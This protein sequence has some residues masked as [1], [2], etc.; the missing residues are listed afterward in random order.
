M[1]QVVNEVYALITVSTVLYY[2]IGFYCI[3]A[4]LKRAL[5]LKCRRLVIMI[6]GLI[7]A[8][9]L[10]YPWSRLIFIFAY[11]SN[12]E[13]LYWLAAIVG[14]A[15]GSLIWFALWTFAIKLWALAQSLKEIRERPFYSRGFIVILQ[16]VGISALAIGTILLMV[17]EGLYESEALLTA[18]NAFIVVV[19]ISIVCVFYDAYRQIRSVGGEQEI[20]ILLDLKQLQMFVI[21]FAIILIPQIFMLLVA[22]VAFN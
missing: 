2:P 1:T 4:I 21:A 19:N 7:S 14:C 15:S 22:F 17:A 8:G 11:D 20:S 10:I 13:G 16:W 9:T 12:N 6:L 3:W 18:A 5:R